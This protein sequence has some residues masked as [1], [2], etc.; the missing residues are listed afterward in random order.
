MKSNERY[1]LVTLVTVTIDRGHVIV[2]PIRSECII[3]NPN[4]SRI[5][6]P[7]STDQW[8]AAAQ[9]VV[10]MVVVT[11]PTRVHST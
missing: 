9:S 10:R 3:R 8:L 2:A 11:K 4:S 5:T 6:P 7:S 1:V